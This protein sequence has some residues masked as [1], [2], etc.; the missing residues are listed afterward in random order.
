MYI[1]AHSPW[2][3]KMELLVKNKH[4]GRR[5][6]LGPLLWLAFAAGLLLQVFAPHLKI[7]NNKFVMPASILS[8]QKDVHP[9]EIVARERRIQALSGILTLGSGLGLGLYYRH[10]LIGPRSS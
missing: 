10:A 5:A 7:Q 4:N 2:V 9:D 6:W 8:G 3:P 1:R